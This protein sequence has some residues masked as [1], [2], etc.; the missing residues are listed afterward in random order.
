MQNIKSKS[1]IARFTWIDIAKGIAT[2]LV[3][4]RHVLY[5]IGRRGVDVGDILWNLNEMVY[6]FR[7]PLFFILSGI[8]FARSVEKRSRGQ[9]ITYKARTLMYPY[10]LWA[11]I[12]VTLQVILS[13]YTNSDR[14]LE[15]YLFILIKPRAIDQL[16]FLYTL[17]NVTILYFFVK[18]IVRIPKAPLLLLTLLSLYFSSYFEQYS[19]ISDMLFFTFF[20]QFGDVMSSKLRS[21]DFQQLIS[22]KKAMWLMLPV[23]ALSQ[24][25]FLENMDDIA[26][27]ELAAVALFGSIYTIAFSLMIADYKWSDFFESVGR[28]SLQIYVMHVIISSSFRIASTEL[29]GITNVYFLLALGMTTGVFIPLYIVQLS[30]KYPKINWLFNYPK[31]GS[32]ASE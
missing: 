31:P 8:F 6:S 13:R 29:L 1:G 32:L 3:V 12:Q 22:S 15:D 14:G 4:Y 18:Y 25:Y 28:N 2:L 16:W 5:G 23:F 20:F 27:Y 10:I 21:I 9:F 30:K 19:L 24:W 26:T 11:L 17:F 7:M